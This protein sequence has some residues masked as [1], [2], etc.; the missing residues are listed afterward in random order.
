MLFLS[1]TIGF[2]F[3]FMGTIKLTPKINEGKIQRILVSFLFKGIFS[4]IYRL[5]RKI[6]IKQAKAFPL[7]TITGYRPSGHLLRKC[8]GTNEVVS[9]LALA[10]VPGPLK[11]IANVA[12]LGSCIVQVYLQ[13][14]AGEALDKMTPAVVFS[15]LL[16]CRLAICMQLFEKIRGKAFGNPTTDDDSDDG[17]ED[18]TPVERRAR[19]LAAAKAKLEEKIA[20]AKAKQATAASGDA[21][22]SNQGSQTV[23][24]GGP[25]KKSD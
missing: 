11:N 14:A 10:I 4:E 9:G 22:T 20:A 19:K 23:A 8:I 18:E 2:F 5:M 12:L 6:F 1:M 16:L 15:L 13:W 17:E 25:D 21:S 7:A 24:A 3:V